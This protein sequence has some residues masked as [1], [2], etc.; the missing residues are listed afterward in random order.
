M[1][2]HTP[3]GPPPKFL[4]LLKLA[5]ANGVKVVSLHLVINLFQLIMHQQLCGDDSVR[6]SFAALTQNSNWNCG[7]ANLTL[8]SPF[9]KTS[10]S[11]E[12]LVLVA[13]L[14]DG[15]ITPGRGLVAIVISLC[16]KKSL[17][18]RFLSLLPGGNR[19]WSNWP[20][21]S[22]ANGLTR[23]LN[24]RPESSRLYFFI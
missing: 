20:W 3:N 1:A 23:S 19:P 17:L 16:S 15:A 18:S 4:D 13:T 12:L 8:V 14:R 11:P 24:D 5:G 2:N 22:H 6:L 21:S 7:V 10:L 9:P